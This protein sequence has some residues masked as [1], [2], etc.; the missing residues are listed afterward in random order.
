MNF[1]NQEWCIFKGNDK[2]WEELIKEYPECTYLDRKEW[3]IHLEKFGWKKIRLTKSNKKTGQSIIQGFIKFLPFS[4]CIVWI[5]GGI[6]GPYEN[7]VNFPENLKKILKI[8]FCL[9]RIR[10]H[11][12][13]DPKKEIELLKNRFRRPLISLSTKFKIILNLEDSIDEISKRFS[14]SWKR[15][16]KKSFENKIKIIHIKNSKTISDIYKDMKSN[17]KLTKKNIYTENDC[18]SIIKAFGKDLVILGAEDK[19]TKRIIAIRGIILS[20][21]KSYDIFA[22]SNNEGR[23][24]LASHILLYSLIKE[25]I[26]RGCKE[27]DLSNID[28]INS[29]GV[30]NFKKGT[31]GKIIQTLGEFE[32]TNSFF[33]KVL[34]FFYSL[35]K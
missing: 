27:Y 21:K 4:N 18:I 24:L 29:M 34:I 25:S 6:L 12:I 10:S 26:N 35:F 22:A 16:L 8:S 30:Y 5:P 11:Q 1:K 28:P 31:G 3:S 2:E 33:L 13:Y 7:L 14:R 9:I 23:K 20:N 32:W 15:S 17:K 19:N